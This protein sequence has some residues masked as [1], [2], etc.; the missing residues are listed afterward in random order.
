MKTRKELLAEHNSSKFTNS[1]YD[2]I[3]ESVKSIDINTIID[4]NDN[5]SVAINQV[6]K[7]TSYLWLRLYLNEDDTTTQASDTI[8]M[9][10]LDYD[11][12]LALHFVC[13]AKTN[14]TQDTNE[15]VVN[16]NPED[17]KKVLCMMVE[18]DAITKDNK[19]E[20]IKTMFKTLPWF[21]KQYFRPVEL[22]FTNE[23]TGQVYDY[24]SADF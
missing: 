5:E 2:S 9:H 1:L 12:K 23:R 6:Q 13:Y 19:L 16:Y 8:T 14:T 3:V 11:E 15:A 4:G 20:Y 22:T 21:Q 18:E 24:Y 7:S 17:D 10:Y